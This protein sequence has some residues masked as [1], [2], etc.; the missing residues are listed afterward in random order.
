MVSRVWQTIENKRSNDKGTDLALV[1]SVCNER[2]VQEHATQVD[3]V[4]TENNAKVLC[5]QG[6]KVQQ[7]AVT[8]ALGTTQL[9]Q[10]LSRDAGAD[11]A[12]HQGGISDT[13]SWTEG[14]VLRQVSDRLNEPQIEA[15]KAAQ[16]E[17]TTSIE[18]TM[19]ISRNFSC[20]HGAVA[21]GK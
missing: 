15:N 17:K 14:P 6:S 4:V 7:S 12:T 18:P 1:R 20:E 8:V 2:L 16:M 9:Q 19:K 11:S 10:G 5:G 3:Q 21:L 13:I